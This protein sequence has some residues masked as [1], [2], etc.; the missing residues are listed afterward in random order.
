MRI[1]KP[2]E[3]SL[4]MFAEGLIIG[5]RIVTTRRQKPTSLSLRNIGKAQKIKSIC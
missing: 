4:A 1:L 5:L 3:I 2:K